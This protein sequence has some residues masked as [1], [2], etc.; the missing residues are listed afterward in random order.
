MIKKWFTLAELRAF[1]VP[2]EVTRRLA[3]AY[4]NARNDDVRVRG[5]SMLTFEPEFSMK[6]L[7]RILPR[8]YRKILTEAVA[9]G[10]VVDQLVRLGIQRP[11]TRPRSVYVGPDVDAE[12]AELEEQLQARK[13]RRAA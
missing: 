12:I 8:Q 1:G 6:L 9:P 11:V 2:Q 4:G 3:E 7:Q 10:Y 13:A 5:D